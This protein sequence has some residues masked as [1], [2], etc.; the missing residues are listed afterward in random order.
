MK[1]MEEE[2]MGALFILCIVHVKVASEFVV[3]LKRPGHSMVVA[4][5]SLSHL[6]WS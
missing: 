4:V 3:M 6:V 1:R 5:N 2:R